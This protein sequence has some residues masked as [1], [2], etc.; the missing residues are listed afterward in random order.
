MR[1]LLRDLESR[2]HVEAWQV[3]QAQ[4]ALHVLDQH[5]LPR[6]WAQPWP[7]PAHTAETVRTLPRR[8]AF[9]DEP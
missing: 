1:A 5:G 4:E 8:Q 6:P 3:E 2:T 9:R 7:L